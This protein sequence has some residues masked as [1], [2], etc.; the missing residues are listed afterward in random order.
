MSKGMSS[1]SLRLLKEA[2]YDVKPQL[3]EYVLHQEFEKKGIKEQWKCISCQQEYLAPIPVSGVDCSK[4]HAM[5]RVWQSGE[6]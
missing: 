6:L 3:M 4:G 1:E 2:G 5:R